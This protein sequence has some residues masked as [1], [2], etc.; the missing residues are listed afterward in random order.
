M[1]QP[2]HATPARLVIRIQMPVLLLLHLVTVTASHVRGPVNKYLVQHQLAVRTARVTPVLC[3][4]VH[5]WHILTA[6]AVQ[7]AQLNQGVQRIVKIV[8]KP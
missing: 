2:V 3:R 1:V 4:P 6:Q 5:T 7:M 8:S